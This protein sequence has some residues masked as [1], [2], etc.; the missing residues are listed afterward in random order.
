MD[1]LIAFL[2]ARI[3]ED[4][5]RAQACCPVR[6]VV[7]PFGVQVDPAEIRDNKLAYGNLGYVAGS[8]PNELGFAYREHIARHDPARVLAEVDAKRRI[9]AEY[10]RFAA[11]RRRMMGGWD[12]GD[13]S[14]ILAALAL[15]YAD[16]PGYRQE[17][18]P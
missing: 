2:C 8:D 4:E 9:I 1:D 10:E 12:P 5:Q 16:Q 3:A 11:E 15:P 6:W 14:P 17:W 13:V 18:K 7:G